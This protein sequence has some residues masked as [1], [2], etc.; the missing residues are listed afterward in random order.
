[1]TIL[2]LGGGALGVQA[3]MLAKAAGLRVL[4]ADKNPACPAKALA[5]EFMHIDITKAAL[6]EADFVLPATESQAILESLSGKNLL[7]DLAAW[8]KTA[9]RLTADEFLRSIGVAIPEYFP[10]GSEPYLVKPDRGSFG[11]GIWVTEDFCEVGGAVNAGFVT[12]EELDGPVWSQVVLGIPG[13]YT[14]YAPAKLSFDG[15]QRT[16]AECLPAP[17]AETLADTAKTIAEAI[18]LSGMLEVEAIFHRGQWKVIDLNAR[19]PMYTG[20]ALLE[21]GINLLGEQIARH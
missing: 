10:K 6:P 12:Q 5:D 11:M 18:G 16:G 20:E 9:S 4:L 19:L 7:F 17:D 15:R 14:A 21:T 2:I 3:A 1:M 13:A 8:N